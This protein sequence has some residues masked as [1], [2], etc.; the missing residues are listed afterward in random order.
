MLNL[1]S[2]ILLVLVSSQA[3]MS[4]SFKVS[5]VLIVISCKFPM[6]VGH[7]Y[8]IFSPPKSEC[9]FKSYLILFYHKLDFISV[10]LIINYKLD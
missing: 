10:I 9:I 7:K 8:M 4:T 1:S 5:M 2:N 6:G 3:I